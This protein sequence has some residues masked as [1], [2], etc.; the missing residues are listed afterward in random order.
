MRANRGPLAHI[1][2]GAVIAVILLGVNGWA[3]TR[4]SHA[5]S[6]EVSPGAASLV[7]GAL[8]ACGAL[9]AFLLRASLAA[10]M[11]HAVATVITASWGL[12][13]VPAFDFIDGGSPSEMVR[14]G[15]WSPG[16]WLWVGILLAVIAARL[17]DG[18]GPLG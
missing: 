3:V 15:A 9:L 1:V 14:S 4:S 8:I 10:L 6:G 13:T 12:L 11:V 16:V 7:L 17:R 5:F 18:E 2:G